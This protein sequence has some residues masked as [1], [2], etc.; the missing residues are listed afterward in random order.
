MGKMAEKNNT[1]WRK[2]TKRVIDETEAHEPQPAVVGPK[3]VHR[4]TASEHDPFA[5]IDVLFNQIM[6]DFGSL[7]GKG[8]F[9][10]VSMPGVLKMEGGIF[11]K[12][13][14]NVRETSK[15]VN[16]VV[17]MPGIKK[18]DIKIKID[19]RDLI[20]DAQIKSSLERKLGGFASFSS[21]YNGYRNVIRLPCEIEKKTSKASYYNGVLTINL[22]K[23]PSREGPSDIDIE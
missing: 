2:Y 22:P 3:H 11:R 6:K 20:I 17:E 5:G 23:K 12:P 15:E 8:F 1:W 18:E 16:V 10:P 7:F 21:S 14:V 9:K 13:P 19:G 4:K